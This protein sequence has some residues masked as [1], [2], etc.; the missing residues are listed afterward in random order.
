M[1]YARET[2]NLADTGIDHRN[3]TQVTLDWTDPALAQIIRIRFV[4]DRWAGPFDLSYVLGL[5][6]EDRQ[7]RVRIP[8]YQVRGKGS[9]I[10]PELVE[11]ARQDGIYL[12][13]LCG[14]DIDSVLSVIW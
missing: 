6:T 7:V 1:T 12:K 8:V 5:D 4:G 2:N 3:T 9:R 10:K 14:G 11:A 13:R